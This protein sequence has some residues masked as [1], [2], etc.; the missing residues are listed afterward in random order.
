MKSGTMF[1]ILFFFVLTMLDPFS[2]HVSIKIICRFLKKKKSTGILVDC[3]VV[4]LGS[5]A[6]LILS[7]L[8]NEH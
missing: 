1:T 5:T 4:N 8:I 2:F 7:L 6:M 3:I